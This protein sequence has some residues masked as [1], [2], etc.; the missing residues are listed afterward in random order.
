[1]KVDRKVVQTE[2]M[3]A[4]MAEKS[5]SQRDKKKADWKENPRA[6]QRVGMRGCQ[7]AEKWVRLL[8]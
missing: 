6:I 1:M 3:L 7:R 2:E 4:A 8:V 5:D